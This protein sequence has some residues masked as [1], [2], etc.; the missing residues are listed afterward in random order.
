MAKPGPKPRIEPRDVLG[1]FDRRDDRGEPLTAPELAESLNCSRRTALN[2]LSDLADDGL[3]RSK[4]VGG[5][6]RV[7]WTPIDG[8]TSTASRSE[9]AREKDIAASGVSDGAPDPGEGSTTPDAER[10][11][12]SRA[13]AIDV[14]EDLGDALD[15]LDVTDEQ[16]EAVAAMYEYLAANGTARK[17]GFVDDV[18]PDHPAGY[19]SEGGWWNRLGKDALATLPGVQKPAEG[20]PTWRF[21]RL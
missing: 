17:S 8:R 9:P 3:L 20:R 6:S 16:R 10:A 15:G 18:Y 19:A 11:R 2:R 13:E 5:R 1:V 21:I 14:S 4:Q 7:Y 12:E